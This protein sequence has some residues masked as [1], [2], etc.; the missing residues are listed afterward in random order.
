MYPSLHQAL[1]TLLVEL[2]T[3]GAVGSPLQ[4]EKTGDTNICQH[5]TRVSLATL[6]FVEVVDKQTTVA[7]FFLRSFAQT[8]DNEDDDFLDILPLL[9]SSASSPREKIQKNPNV[10]S[11]LISEAR[12]RGTGQA[13]CAKH[14]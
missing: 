14:I 3:E 4:P 9:E 13:L 8:F 7:S 12:A 10:L 1:V 6:K 2:E 5:P 11:F